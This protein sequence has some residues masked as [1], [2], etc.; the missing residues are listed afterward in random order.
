MDSGLAAEIGLLGG[1]LHA[2]QDDGQHHAGDEEDP[3]AVNCYF[4]VVRRRR[5][6]FF[7]FRSWIGSFEEGTIMPQS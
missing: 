3:Y 7:F 1:V 2:A 4:H 6:L 5:I